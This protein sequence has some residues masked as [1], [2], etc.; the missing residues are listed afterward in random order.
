MINVFN[1]LEM[2]CS[3]WD[4]VKKETISN[5][6]RHIGF[7]QAKCSTEPVENAEINE[8]KE[9]TTEFNQYFTELSFDE[10]VDVDNSLQICEHLQETILPEFDKD[11]DEIVDINNPD[12]ELP[13]EKTKI[14]I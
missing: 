6:F 2:C 14:E 1:A 7:F 4:D 10:F 13:N 12:E 11:L 9:L 3:S 8:L 5:C